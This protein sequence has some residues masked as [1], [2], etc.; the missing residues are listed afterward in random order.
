MKNHLTLPLKV[1]IEKHFN[2]FWRQYFAVLP[3]YVLQFCYGMSSAFPAV[4]TPQ[5][6]MDCALFPISS[7]E[8]SWIGKIQFFY[9]K[10]VQKLFCFLVLLI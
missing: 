9:K 4:T 10:I 1:F 8:E 3:V 2:D 6:S 7:E 5:L